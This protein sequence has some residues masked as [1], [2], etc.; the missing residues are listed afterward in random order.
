MGFLSDVAPCG[1]YTY[2]P[3][4]HLFPCWW[5]KTNTNMQVSEGTFVRV[6]LVFVAQWII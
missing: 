4:G 2:V 3:M 1:R 5:I 6:A